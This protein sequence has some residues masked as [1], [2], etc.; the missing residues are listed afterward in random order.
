MPIIGSNILTHT[1]LDTFQT[2]RRKHQFAYELGV[3][4]EAS[5]ALRIG[6]AVH[7]GTEVI[8]NGGTTDAAISAVVDNYQPLIESAQTAERHNALLYERE[9]CIRLVEGW[10]WRWSQASDFVV[11]EVELPLLTDIINPES[12]RSS[13]TFRYGGKADKLIR[14]D[15]GRMA[16]LERKTTSYSVEADSNYWQ[17]LRLDSQI[18]R[19]MVALRR[20]G[21]DVTVALYDV[22]R[23]PSIAPKQVADLDTH[24]RKIVVDQLGQRAYKRNNEPRQ[25]GDS[26]KG[27]TVKQHIETPDEY[28]ERLMQDIYDRPDFYFAR[29]EVPRLQSD[30]DE[31]AQELWDTADSMRLA[32]NNGH[33]Y[34]NTRACLVPYQCEYLAVCSNGVDLA[35]EMPEGFVQLTRLH[36]ELGDM[37]DDIATNGAAETA[38]S[39]AQ[40]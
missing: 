10:V 3:R 38:D 31:A 21:H 7:L 23:K 34:R 18:S 12:G 27:L 32:R 22:I 30:L 17:A 19:Y 8:G 35:N 36:P 24:G 40:D 5:E 15:D 6:S 16:L 13:R 28:G 11:I 26:A 25:S 33:H 29:R 2:C 4:R 14:L 1:R 37:Y 39:A 9:K 20:M